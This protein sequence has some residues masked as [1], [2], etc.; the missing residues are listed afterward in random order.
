M[1]IIIGT[2]IMTQRSLRMKEKAGVAM[3][4]Y[5]PNTKIPRARKK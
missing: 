2:R 3:D 5:T 4:S 1:N